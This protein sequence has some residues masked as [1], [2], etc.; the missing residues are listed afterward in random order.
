MIAKLTLVFAVI[1]LS[2]LLHQ[3][4]LYLRGLMDEIRAKKIIIE[5]LKN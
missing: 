4:I 3:L 1:T 5:R 2:M